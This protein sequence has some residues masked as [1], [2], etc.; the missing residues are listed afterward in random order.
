[1]R[2]STTTHG[3]AHSS[4]AAVVFRLSPAIVCSCFVSRLTS[5]TVPYPHTPTL[6]YAARM[7]GVQHPQVSGPP[8]HSAPGG[9]VW[10]VCARCGQC[11]QCVSLLV[12]GSRTM[13]LLTSFVALSTAEMTGDAFCTV[14]EFCGDGC[15]LD[16]WLKQ[17]STLSE[18]V[19]LP[20][21]CALF[22]CAVIVAGVSK[23]RQR[24]EVMCDTCDI[25]D[26]RGLCF[27]CLM[28]N[29]RS[30]LF[31]DPSGGK[32]H[33]LPGGLGAAIP[34]RARAC[35][36]PL[37]PQARYKKNRAACRAPRSAS[38][39]E[40]G[41]R[42]RRGQPLT[43]SQTPRSQPAVLRRRGQAD[44]LWPQQRYVPTSLPTFV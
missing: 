44:R 19:R 9:R 25:P 37:R 17:H 24:M 1:M 2:K 16:F 20:T 12:F 7:P 26:V 39:P 42:M 11:P 6:T 36:H 3:Y 18:R 33:H 23:C 15:D 4:R 22:N 34:Q 5:L 13:H 10:Y 43:R 35:R 30:A 41:A 38:S 28:F 31:S 14:L 21:H 40:H 29:P 27:E 32:V 8:A